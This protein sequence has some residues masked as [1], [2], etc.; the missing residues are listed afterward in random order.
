MADPKR[1]IAPGLRE[2]FDSPSYMGPATFGMRPLLTEPSQL[3]EWMPDVAII[4]APW[5]DNTTNRDRLRRRD[6]QPRDVGALA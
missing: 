2:Q 3:D 4:G 5:D 1:P 6:R